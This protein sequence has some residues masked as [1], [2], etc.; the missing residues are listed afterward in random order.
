MLPEI[1]AHISMNTIDHWD[2]QT[3]K[4]LIRIHI[5]YTTL[6]CTEVA[7]INVFNFQADFFHSMTIIHS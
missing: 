3:S 4:T 5:M 2:R 7:K 6:F 1:L